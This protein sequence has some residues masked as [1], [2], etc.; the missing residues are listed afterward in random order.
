MIRAVLEESREDSR[1]PEEG[2]KRNARK[3][4][5]GCRF[6][7]EVYQAEKSKQEFYVE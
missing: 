7:W 2:P 5:Q 6:N 1:C 3:A 4:F